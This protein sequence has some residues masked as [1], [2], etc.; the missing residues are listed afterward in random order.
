MK[1][2]KLFLIGIGSCFIIGMGIGKT[3]QRPSFKLTSNDIQQNQMLNKAQVY[4]AHGCE[5]YNI[6]PQL[7]WSNAP[8]G[9][10]S[11]AVICHDP[12]APPPTGW[13]HW[14]VVNIPASVSEIASG[15]KINGAME[16]I[17]DFKQN[18]YG[19]ACPPI[20]HGLHHYN[21]T[22]YALDCEKIDV[23]ASTSPVEVEKLVKHHA[24][25]KATL[26]GLYERK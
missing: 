6:S 12:D 13:Y 8:Q 22:V 25:A 18:A 11:F 3:M 16:T 21:F 26:T 23:L 1:N 17:T 20:G 5:G 19:G 2:I 10:K 24:L 4:N 14:L 9:T 7:A 15:G